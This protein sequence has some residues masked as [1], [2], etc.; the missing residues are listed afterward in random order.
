MN[1][2]HRTIVKFIRSSVNS[3]DRSSVSSLSFDKYGGY[4]GGD[5]KVY[6][7]HTLLNID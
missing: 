6:P 3:I 5:P 4:S 1:S 7:K 2:F